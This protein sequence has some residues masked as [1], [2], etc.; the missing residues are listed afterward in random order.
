MSLAEPWPFWLGGAFLGAVTVVHL[1]WTGRILSVSGIVA[2]MLR[3]RQDQHER[4]SEL[5]LSKGS[6]DDALLA[7]TLRQFGEQA[8]ALAPSCDEDSMSGVCGSS[9][10]VRLPVSA[11]AV[12][13]VAMA[14]GGTISAL[15][16]GGPTIEWTLGDEFE[17]LAPG[18][19]A[20]VALPLAGGLMVG[21]GARMAGGCTSSHGLSGCARLER[22]SLTATAA[23]FAGGVAISL[24]LERLS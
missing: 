14:I 18:A 5:A 22:G 20:S 13:L 24:L 2:R 11:G 17:R 15:L 8:R 10:R 19:F 7:A 16:A 23:F 9:N 4:E 21:F 1:A 6:L 3:W 12:F